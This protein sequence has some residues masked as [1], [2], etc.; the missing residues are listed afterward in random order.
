MPSDDDGVC[1]SSS[2]T[3]SAARER[4]LVLAAFFAADVFEADFFAAERA[5][6]FAGAIEGRAVAVVADAFFATFFTAFFAALFVTVFVT[7]FVADFAEAADDATAV[8]GVADVPVA[9]AAD[10]AADEATEGLEDFFI[11]MCLV[12]QGAGACAASV[13]EPAFL[14]NRADF[15]DPDS[16][17]D[18]HERPFDQLLEIVL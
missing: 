16:A 13:V 3:D 17:V 4:A 14:R 5:G 18:V 2:A 11:G 7:A 15:S 1:S 8:F 9:R 12:H 6:A 10:G